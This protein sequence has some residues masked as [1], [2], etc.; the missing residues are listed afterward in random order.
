MVDFV[1]KIFK[2]EIMYYV[3]VP[4]IIPLFGWVKSWHDINEKNKKIGYWKIKFRRGYSFHDIAIRTYMFMLINMM[5]MHLLRFVC[6]FWIEEILSYT[7]VGFVYVT[8]NIVILNCILKQ[9]KTK[10]ELWTDK[11][12]KKVLLIT[13]CFILSIAFFERLLPEH[14]YFTKVAFY[15][16]LIGWCFIL[17]YCSDM[18][19]ILDKRYADIYINGTESVKFIYAGNMKKRGGWIYVYRYIDGYEEEIRIKESEIVRID[20]YGEPL[21]DIQNYR[22]KKN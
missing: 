16:G 14:Q 20:Y 9:Y 3:I 7:I 21:V 17:F 1:Q 10:M 18:I 8:I 6:S 22:T 4:I 12:L 13:L 5:I 15:I 2:N 19:Y 11:R